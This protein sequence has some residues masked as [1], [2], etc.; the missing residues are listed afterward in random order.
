MSA[1]VTFF[2]PGVAAPQGSKR[3]L[4]RGV[5]VESSKRLPG[6]RA[7]VRGT[8]LARLPQPVSGPVALVATFCFPRPKAHY[9]TGKYAELLR[10]AAPGAWEHTNRPD[11]DKLL[12]AVLDALTGVV[13]LDDSQVTR[14]FG[15]KRWCDPGEPPGA[16]IH[17]AGV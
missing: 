7:D 11:V 12:R 3:Y 9:R 17:V 10:P 13:W 16:E 8:A 2:V 6:W 5:M 1:T 15:A 4:G 14:V